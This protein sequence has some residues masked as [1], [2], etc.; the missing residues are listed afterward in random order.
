MILHA[1]A[2][3]ENRPARIRTR[4]INRDDAD[5]LLLF[6]ILFGELIDERALARSRSASEP[7]DARLATMRE[8]CF[9]Q[10]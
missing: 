6:A 3:S 8:E 10:L 5:R 9:E 1:N 4:R 2:V 7:D